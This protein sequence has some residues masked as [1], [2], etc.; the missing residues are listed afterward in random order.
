[1]DRTFKRHFSSLNRIREKSDNSQP[2]TYAASRF[3]SV[4]SVPLPGAHRSDP[5]I[6]MA[7]ETREYF[8]PDFSNRENQDDFEAALHSSWKT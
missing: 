6:D 8:I 3:S 4:P 1:V 7:G 5:G 2:V